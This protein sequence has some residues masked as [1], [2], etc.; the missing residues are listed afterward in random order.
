M[1]GGAALAAGPEPFDVAAVVGA[2]AA[3]FEPDPGVAT[4]GESAGA[5]T[6]GV[7]VGG[8]AT[9]ELIWLRSM[10][11]PSRVVTVVDG[12]AFAAAGVTCEPA[13]SIT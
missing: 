6:A 5:P 8:V 1:I 7:V 4:E 12:W 3:A 9:P 2:T 11:R 13:W 10:I